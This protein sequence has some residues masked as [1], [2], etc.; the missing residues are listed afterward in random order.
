MRCDLEE[1]VDYLPTI[2]ECAKQIGVA[3]RGKMWSD[4]ERLIQLFRLYHY[5]IYEQIHNVLVP[6]KT[7][8]AEKEIRDILAKYVIGY[9]KG[10]ISYL[11]VLN[12]LK[13]KMAQITKARKVN[14]EYASEYLDLYD[15]FLALASFRSFEH[16]ALYIEKHL[17]K[18]DEL[19]L[20]KN[21][22]GGDN[23]IIEHTLP[24]FK[25][26]Y[27]YAT[28]MVLDGQVKFI[29]KQM[30]T[31]YGKSYG[32]VLL[33]SFIY[34]YDVNN[35]V[36]KVFGNPYNCERC[37]ESIVDIM[38]RKE[39][40]KVFPYY[41]QF[42]GDKR[43]M[44][45]KCSTK[46]GSFKISGSTRPVS[47]LCVGKDSKI[48][49]VRGKFIFLDDITQAED[50]NI[51]NRHTADIG[52]YKTVWKKRTYGKNNTYIIAGGTAY[53]IYDLLSYLKRK[54]GYEFAV[55]SK[56]HRY[57]S[58]ARSNEIVANG[59]SA[60]IIVPKLDYETDESTYP[61]EFDTFSARKDREEDYETFMAMEQQ[62][63]VPPK[64][65]PFYYTNLNEYSNIPEK[66]S[67]NRSKDCVATLDGKRKGDDFCA[68][69]ICSK[70][71]GKYHLIDAF[72][73]QRAM[74]DCYSGIVSKII[75]HH[76]TRLYVESNINEGLPLILKQKLAEQGYFDCQIDEIFNWEKK[77]DRIAGCEATIKSQLI[78]PQ[79]GMYAPSSQVGMAL[80][81][82]YTY[83]YSVKV[84]HDDF[85]DALST[86]CR[87]FVQENRNMSATMT[88]FK[89]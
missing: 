21:A 85:T 1:I 69:P 79:F 23:K 7:D 41:A 17:T 14:H 48:S 80:Q 50:A 60:F 22:S 6:K 59:I 44:F 82:L 16:F 29:A 84:P 52:K 75:Q 3:I 5:A 57:T 9:T 30:P 32:D 18:N 27:Y 86:F 78:F 61:E 67:A 33:I 73:D 71:N 68:M 31:S 19:K 26:W 54:F 72:Y 20:D 65:T 42:N 45:E 8:I 11:G 66:G 25:G 39:Y 38:L 34:G 2:K 24:L 81:E 87:C 77:E 83:S 88:T 56:T 35:D 13:S 58:V 76:I 64:N 12:P 62:V 4:D 28:K 47:F 63:P 53:S 43:Q 10:K 36:I 55:K 74:E 89:R 15:D 37:F 40:S 70:I 49:G 51:I 46:D